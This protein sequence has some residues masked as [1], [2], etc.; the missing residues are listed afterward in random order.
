MK[1]Q[2][3]IIRTDLPDDFPVAQAQE[4]IKN[5]LHEYSDKDIN[6]SMIK[7]VADRTMKKVFNVKT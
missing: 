1:R 7:P 5:T 3:F 6:T 4:N 2:Y